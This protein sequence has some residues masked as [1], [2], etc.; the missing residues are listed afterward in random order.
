M[1]LEKT[2]AMKTSIR[3]LLT[4]FIIFSSLSVLGQTRYVLTADQELI[5]FGTSTLHNWEMVTTTATGQGVFTVDSGELQK[6]ENFKIKFKGED[7]ESGKGIMDRNTRRALDT[8]NTPMISF[9]L[10]ELKRNAEGKLEAW[11]DF[12]AKGNTR[13][14]KFVVSYEIR[15]ELID[16]EGTTSFKMTDFDIEPPVA[17]AGTLR[18]SDVVGIEFYLTFEKEASLDN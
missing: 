17:L 3:L 6:V 7:L 14:I 13:R 9:E 18:T 4:I 16:V 1:S 15:N 12:T 11:G 5:V 10:E 8:E 2:N